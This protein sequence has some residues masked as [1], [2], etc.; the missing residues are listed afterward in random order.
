MV[1]GCGKDQQISPEAEVAFLSLVSRPVLSYSLEVYEHCPEIDGVVVVVK[2]D[3]MESVR[4]MVH[5]FGFSK[6]RKIVA[7]SPVH[8]TSVQAG[9]DALEPEVSMVSIHDAARPCVQSQVVAET[10]KAAKRYGAAVA[11]AKLMAPVKETSKGQKVGKT[12]DPAKLW[13]PQSPQTFKR[14]VLAKALAAAARRKKAPLDEAEAV[15]LN[16]QEVHLVR[17]EPGNLKIATVQDLTLAAALI[18]A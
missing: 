2:K 8:A 14:E 1:I 17:S 6:V 13:L 3:R 16:R 18:P 9:L 5:M 10:V 12:L 11:A 4:D 15:E 7:G